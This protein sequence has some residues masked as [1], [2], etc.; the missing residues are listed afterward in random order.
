MLLETR[1][2]HSQPRPWTF[3]CF[4]ECI[5]IPQYYSISGDS[6]L[7]KLHCWYGNSFIC[8]I[9]ILWFVICWPLGQLQV[10]QWL[11]FQVLWGFDIM[12][13][14][15][16]ECYYDV[17]NEIQIR[18]SFPCLQRGHL[19]TPILHGGRIQGGWCSTTHDLWWQKADDLTH[20]WP[21]SPFL[22]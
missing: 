21:R 16:I 8:L 22:Y 10:N 7:S 4:T 12:E 6:I 3:Q 17:L 19:V 15:Q 20:H 18:S 2:V 1:L 13:E 11:C 14:Q 9:W 5:C